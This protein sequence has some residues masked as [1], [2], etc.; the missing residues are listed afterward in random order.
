MKQIE[1]EI[2]I[3]LI[4]DTFEKTLAGKLQLVRVTAPRFLKKGTGLQD[5]LAGTQVPVSF[6]TKFGEG[7]EI[8]HSL[9]KWKRYKLGKLG[10]KVG[11]GIYTDMDAIRKDERVSPIHSIYV[12]QWDWE[13]VISKKDR[14]ISF[15]K[16]TVSSIYD[17]ILETAFIVG[18]EFG[19]KRKLPP[20][21]TFIHAEELEKKYPKLSPLDREKEIAREY[22][23]VFII[24]IGHPLSSGKPHDMRAAD[25]DDWCTP[26]DKGYGLNGDIILWD[27]VRKDA[28][29]ISSM[30][31]RVD[32]KALKKQ[33][34]MMEMDKEEFHDKVIDGEL[35][36]TIGGGIG[37]SRLCM[38]LL[39]KAHIGEVHSSVWPEEMIMECEKKGIAL[40]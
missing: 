4:K 3:K 31:I 22:G 39:K 29:E 20:E 15:L 14:T 25:Y 2:G 40:L 27:E 21:I 34:E 18:K 16:K 9:A 33:M 26:T 6:K 35:P 32:A 37:Q 38:F 28:I 5:D 8:V 36:L 10:L 30:G 11:Y 1:T 7:V 12:D 24:G 19:P 23:A 13:K 17:A